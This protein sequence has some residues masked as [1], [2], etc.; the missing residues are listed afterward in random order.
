MA[1]NKKEINE[2]KRNITD[3]LLELDDMSPDVE[4]NKMLFKKTLYSVIKLDFYLNYNIN[5]KDVS[6]PIIR[7]LDYLKDYYFI[8][9]IKLTPWNYTSIIKLNIYDFIELIKNNENLYFNH[10]CFL[11]Y[12]D[13]K[14]HPNWYEDYENPDNVT[15]IEKIDE[16]LPRQ[17]SVD[18]LKALRKLTK[19][20]DIADR[21]PDLM[22]Q[23]ANIHYSRNVID[24][25]IESYEDYEKNNK[26]FISSWNLKNLMS[27]F[28]TKKINER[29]I[30]SFESYTRKPVDHNKSEKLAKEIL[31]LLQKKRESGEKVSIGD[32]DKIMND[33]G[34]DSQMAD[35]VMHNLVYLGFDFDNIKD[36]DAGD[37]DFTFINEEYSQKVKWL[38]DLIIDNF[39]FLLNNDWKFKENNTIQYPYFSYTLESYSKNIESRLEYKGRVSNGEI[40]WKN[41]VGEYKLEKF[42]KSIRNIN[43]KSNINIHFSLTN[44]NGYSKL[45]LTGKHN[46]NI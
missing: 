15:K 8:S 14:E 38:E 1:L 36:S 10:I 21:I 22:K 28:K 31:P 18:Q 42:I 29:Y 20:I 13:V 25:G 6:D 7:L 32:F 44:I 9:K 23:G 45:L 5:F 4:F 16:S 33:K 11:F 40:I 41:K 43:E 3:I 27:P 2:I 26:N 12:E 24:S 30:K 19:G 34:I 46:K 37:L 17:K 35:A 39:E